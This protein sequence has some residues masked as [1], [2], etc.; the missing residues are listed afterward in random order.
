L[1]AVSGAGRVGGGWA[2]G[3]SLRMVGAHGCRTA[4][5][6]AAPAGGGSAPAWSKLPCCTRLSRPEHRCCCRCR[7][8]CR[9]DLN[10]RMPGYQVNM[11]FGLHVGAC[12][13][14]CLP[15]CLQLSFSKGP[16]FI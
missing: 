1:R 7:R 16:S 3:R 2:V 6:V 5:V 9:E 13:P 14:R 11:G 8:C 4:A 15:N 12:L 10:R